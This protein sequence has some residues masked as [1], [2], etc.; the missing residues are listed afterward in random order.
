M[1]HEFIIDCREFKKTANVEVVDI[2]KRLQDYGEFITGGQGVDM[3]KDYLINWPSNGNYVTQLSIN[4][5]KRFD[6]SNPISQ[7]NFHFTFV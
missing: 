2:A 1:A 5:E 7:N 3:I 4:Y 6:F